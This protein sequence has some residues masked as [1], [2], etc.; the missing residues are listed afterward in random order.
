MNKSFSFQKLFL[1]YLFLTGFS[2]LTIAQGPSKISQLGQYEGY[3]L[4]NYKGFET[5]SFHLPLPDSVKLAVDL[6]LP[7]GLESDKK[8]PAILYLTRYVRALQP[9]AS[10]RWATGPILGNVPKEEVQYLTSHGYACIIVDVRGT[11]AST[12]SRS[13]EFSAQEIA[14][15]AEV[16]DWIIEQDWSN[17]KVGSTGVSYL[18]TTAELLLVNQHPAV[19]ASVIRSGTFDLYEHITFPGGIRQGPFLEVWRNSTYALDNNNLGFFSLKAGL[20]IKGVQP[21]DGDKGRKKLKAALKEHEANYDVFKEFPKLNYRDQIVETRGKS[22]DE[23]SP[24]FYR[25][26]IEGSNTP[27]YRISGWYDGAN[28]KSAIQAYLGT[29][30]TQKLLI[31]P[32]DH[33]PFEFI[34]PFGRGSKV[35]FSVY[36][37]MLRFFD[38]HLKGIE[39]GILEDPPIHYYNMGQEKWRSAAQWPE[40]DIKDMTYY[41]SSDSSLVRE[42]SKIQSGA[43]PYKIDYTFSSGDGARWHSLTPAYRKDPIGY[44]DWT[45]RAQ[46][47]P[48]FS[49]PPFSKSI[50]ITGYPIV[51]LNLKADATDATIFV[52]LQ[53]QA[54]DG[55]LTYITEGQFRAIHRKESKESPPYP[56]LGP[57]HTFRKA[58]SSPLIPNEPFQVSFELLPTSYQLPPG[59]RLQVTIAGADIDHFDLPV[60]KPSKLDILMENGF[61]TKIRVPVRGTVRQHGSISEE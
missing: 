31:G 49:T 10:I 23:Y 33:G 24:H 51:E 30:N 17:G 46:H 5:Q 45:E 6:H 55:T 25:K 40:P 50:E 58:D 54:P 14:D 59:H 37:E 28:A 57:Y 2:V 60:D 12:G 18:G 11:G 15:G 48:T 3:N 8:I 4:D 19:Q 26:E 29:K 52:Y 47:L 27:M 56:V 7:K 9:V 38:F 32:W 42:E 34:S 22:M 41:F 13:M 43:V 16:V 53:D 21:I 35:T 61:Q 44:P 1:C 39:N 20:L 36:A